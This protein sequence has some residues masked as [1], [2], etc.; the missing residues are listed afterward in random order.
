MSGR[1]FLKTSKKFDA[2]DVPIRLVRAHAATLLLVP[3]FLLATFLPVSA[4]AA[5]P[6]LRENASKFI[7]KTQ[8]SYGAMIAT[9]A[10]LH[11]YDPKLI[12]AVIVV[13]SEGNAKVVSHRGAEGLMQLMP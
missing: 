13:E 11:D 12:L 4:L 7:D 10:L 3:F 8:S 2:E 1:I 9:A 5:T 6:H